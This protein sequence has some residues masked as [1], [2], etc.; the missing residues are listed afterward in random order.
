MVKRIV[1]PGFVLMAVVTAAVAAV[2]LGGSPMV[3]RT[4]PLQWGLMTMRHNDFK[5]HLTERFKQYPTNPAYIMFFYPISWDFPRPWVEV[6]A[7]FDATSMVSIELW[8]WGRNRKPGSYLPAIV[9]GEYDDTFRRWAQGAKEYG[10]RVLIRF[11]FEFN[12]KWFTWSLDPKSYVPAWR[13]IHGIFRE[14]GADNVEWVWSPNIES[15]PDTPE[16]DM[17]LYYPGNA[18][19]DWVGVDG[20]NFGDH[21]DE[22]HKWQ[23]F[24]EVYRQ[25]LDEFDRRYPDKPTIIPEFGSAPG[26]P[27]Q[28]EQWIRDAYAFLQGRPRVKAAIWFDLNKRREGEPNW[29]IDATPE[30]L[31]AFNETFAKKN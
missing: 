16:N 2:W 20:Y 31:Q 4:E 27:G 14:V 28:R 15:C 13:R 23:S 26:K 5:A 30:S 8:Q 25:V 18:Y 22:W 3:A 17:H 6:A 9:A 12:G 11:G 19:V 24:E 1:L 7:E 29:R 10:G 21:H